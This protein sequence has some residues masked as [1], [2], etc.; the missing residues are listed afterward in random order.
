M[1]HNQYKLAMDH[2][3]FP[4]G[5]DRALCSVLSE[6][7]ENNTP[8]RPHSARKILFALV[9]TLLTVIIVIIVGLHT[10]T[11][12]QNNNIAK[13]LELEHNNTNQLEDVT[14]DGRALVKKKVISE[15]TS[16]YLDLASSGNTEYRLSESILRIPENEITLLKKAYLL[17][18]FYLANINNMSIIRLSPDV[19]EIEY[20]STDIHL[21]HAYAVTLTGDII[22]LTPFIIYSDS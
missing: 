5:F 4:D 15:M 7:A 20:A 21:Y 13:E 18:G 2:I 1:T 12:L 14:I 3:P 19:T 10:Q 6:A 16:G 8:V 17:E 22:D 9:I 11:D